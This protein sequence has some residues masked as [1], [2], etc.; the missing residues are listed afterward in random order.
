MTDKKVN[1]QALFDEQS[2]LDPVTSYRSSNIQKEVASKIHKGKVISE[3]TKAKMRE[4]WERRKAENNFGGWI[5]SD[6]TRAK[7]SES[8]KKRWQENPY[9]ATEE[10]NQKRS[11]SLKKTWAERK[12]NMPPKAVEPPK[13]KG[14][15]RTRPLPDPNAPPKRR[16]R[17]PKVL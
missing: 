6:E 10:V 12:A 8:Q 15:P 2:H 9:I 7:Q 5:L 11:E 3:Q 17:P 16:G 4:H 13:K 1:L 14:R